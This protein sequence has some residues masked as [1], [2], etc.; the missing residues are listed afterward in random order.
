MIPAIADPMSRSMVRKA[1][2]KH[3]KALMSAIV[4]NFSAPAE[5][6]SFG[7]LEVDSLS[8]YG[9]LVNS[10][11]IIIVGISFKDALR[12][13]VRTD[14]HAVDK[15]QELADGIADAL[16]ELSKIAVNRTV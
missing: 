3:D 11:G 14:P 10:V 12:I 15:P 7:G 5:E 9:A 13:T 8:G 2:K 6:I 1:S 16:L 4:S